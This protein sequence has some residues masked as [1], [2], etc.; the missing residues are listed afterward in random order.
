MLESDRVFLHQPPASG[1]ATCSL[2][3]LALSQVT[4][5]QGPGLSAHQALLWTPGSLTICTT[6]R[7]F[8]IFKLPSSSDI[9]SLYMMGDYTLT[10]SHLLM[11]YII[12]SEMLQN[13]SLI[14]CPLLENSKSLDFSFAVHTFPRPLFQALIPEHSGLLGSCVEGASSQG[15]DS[16]RRR[17][18]SQAFQAP[19]TFTSQALLFS[20]LRLVLKIHKENVL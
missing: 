19:P 11:I 17:C 4:G 16:S 14:I 8:L 20:F 1:V 18:P 6:R 5:P 2:P 13:S 12:I 9:L 15:R 7:D 10:Q 3:S